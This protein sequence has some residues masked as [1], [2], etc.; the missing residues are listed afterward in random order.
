LFAEQGY[1]ATTVPQIT[2]R[3]GLTTR[4][5]FRHFADKRE[6]VFGGDDIPE[7]A[8]RLVAAAPADLEPMAVL[9]LVLHQVAR[10]RFAGDRTG[11][12][13]WRAMIL[14]NDELRDRDARKRADMVR[15]TQV[16]FIAR[17]QCP[18]EATVL[19]ELGV[20]AFHVALDEWAAAPVDRPMTA[21]VDA[22]LDTITAHTG[23]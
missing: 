18:L 16:A 14:A 23:R 10:V 3:A 4:T 6:V 7:N 19:A 2:A 12:A 13:A 20:L 9:R 21:V 1:A 15:A 22:V 17:G 8:A 5:F 11:V